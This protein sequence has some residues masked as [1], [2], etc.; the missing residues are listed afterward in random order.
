MSKISVNNL[1]RAIYESLKDKEG[2]SLDKTSENVIRLLKNK[3]MMSKSNLILEEIQKIIDEENKIIRAKIKMKR[4]I[5][6][7]T[8]KGIEEFVKKKWEAKDV[9]LEIEKE[10][11]LLGGIKIQVKD[12]IIDL[13]LKNKLEQLQ[14]YLIKN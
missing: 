2:F 14:N 10:E 11:R 1:A 4:N 12:E 3:N 6:I 8:E 9:I 7:N 13:T 5:D